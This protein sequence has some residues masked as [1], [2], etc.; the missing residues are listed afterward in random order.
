[1]SFWDGS[2]WVAAVPPAAAPGTKPSSRTRRLAAATLEAGLITALTFGLIAGTAFAG[3]ASYTPTLS[4]AWPETLSAQDASSNPTPY[5]VVGCGYNPAYGG[6]T[7]V[8]TSPE[9]ISFS[10]GMPDADGCISVGTWYT[11]GAGHYDVEAFQQVHRKS[12]EVASTAF[13]L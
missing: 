12:T 2:K 6:V 11:Q 1:M 8:V 4:V 7:V 3:K 13:D 10:G 9:S 5:R